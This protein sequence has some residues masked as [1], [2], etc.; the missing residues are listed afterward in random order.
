MLGITLGAACVLTGIWS[1]IIWESIGMEVAGI[2]AILIGGLLIE[3]GKEGA[4]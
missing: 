1:V 2:A 4:E 3:L